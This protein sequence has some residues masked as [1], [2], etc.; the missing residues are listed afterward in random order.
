[1]TAIE[2]EPGGFRLSNLWS[3]QRSRGILIQILALAA[4]FALFAYIVNNTLNNLELLG[5]EVGYAF[6]ADP[7]GY[8]INQRLIDYDSRDSHGRAA[9][10]GILN[11]LLVGAC[12]IAL[13]TLVGFT[14][15]VLRLSRNLLVNRLVYGY[16]EFTRNVPL[17]L[18][19][20]L[21]HA[22]IVHSL[23]RPKQAL[24]PLSGVFLS[25]RGFALPRP[26]LEPAFWAVALATLVA[27]FGAYHFVRYARKMQADTGRQ[28]PVFAVTAG[29]IVVLP[30]AAFFLAGMPATLDWPA[31]RGFNFQGGV[32]IRPEFMALWFALSFYHGAFIAENVR[33]GIQAVSHGQ[34]EAAYALG[35]R[36]NLTMRLVVLP[37][38]LRVIVPPLISQYMNLVKNSSLAIAVGYMDI[39]ATIGGITLNQTGRA[40]ECMSIVIAI[41]LGFSL[42]ISAFMNWYNKRVALVER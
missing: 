14:A 27:I 35:L 24:E 2:L 19:I 6:L 15:G 10:V 17:L 41:Y 36:P 33:A 31:L 9:L 37:Q 13:A 25:N 32:T 42:T 29:V 20:L 4:L 40:L 1:M 7:A 3:D 22:V 26:E 38:A 18:Q 16:V 23:P 34:T 11:T 8:D 12:A 30:L 28:L 5:L 39:V 21:W